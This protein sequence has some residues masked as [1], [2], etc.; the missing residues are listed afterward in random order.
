MSAVAATVTKVLPASSVCTAIA[1]AHR[2]FEP[3]MMPIVS[4]CDPDG[5]AVDVGA[6]YAPWTHWLSRRVE[7]VVA[8]EPNP[9]VA[10]VIRAWVPG[11]AEVRQLAVSDGPGSVS[12]AVTGTHRFEEGRSYIDLTDSADNRVEVRTTRLDDEGLDR[13]RLV[14]IDVEGHE[15]AALQGA[16]GVLEGYHPVVVVE[17]ETRYGDVGPVFELLISLGYRARILVDRRWERTGAE[18]LAN[19]QLRHPPAQGGYLKNATRRGN[20]YVN[21]VVFAHPESTWVPW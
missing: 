16:I 11:N 15:L 12:L 1:Y 6:W 21:N 17:L 8:F 10:E 5:V 13:V 18:A 3:E 4:A 2:R 9:S 7:R 19:R 20:G 14:K